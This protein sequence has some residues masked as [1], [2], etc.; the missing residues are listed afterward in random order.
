MNLLEQ[1]TEFSLPRYEQEGKSY[2]TLAIGCTGGLHRSVF[3]AEK[4]LSLLQRQGWA[5]SVVHREL[6]I[7]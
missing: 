2:L 1:F 6:G 7:G 3:I 4:M 5:A